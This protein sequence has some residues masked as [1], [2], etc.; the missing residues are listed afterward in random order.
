M[1]MAEAQ[2]IIDGVG[3]GYMVSFGWV[4]GSC[5]RLDFFPDK[6]AG[7]D[8]IPTEEEAWLLA[9]RFAEKTKGRAVNIYVMDA[10]FSPVAGYEDRSIKNR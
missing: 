6:H 2:A 4:E 7:E 8:L 1:L 10:T 9:E 3:L 5:L